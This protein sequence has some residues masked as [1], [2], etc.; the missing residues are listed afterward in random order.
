LLIPEQQAVEISPAVGE[1]HRIAAVTHL[2]GGELLPGL[3][4]ELQ[5]ISSVITRGCKLSSRAGLAGSA[6][7]QRQAQPDPG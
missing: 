3:R 5:D 1:P 2:D 7:R 6:V 4:V